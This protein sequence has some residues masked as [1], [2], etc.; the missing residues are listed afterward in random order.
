MYTYRALPFCPLQIQNKK[1]SQLQR[2]GSILSHWPVYKSGEVE[3]RRRGGGGTM[4]VP[5]G[6]GGGWGGGLKKRPSG[7]GGMLA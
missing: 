1:H 6:E 4:G 3:E 2:K 7:S 5:G